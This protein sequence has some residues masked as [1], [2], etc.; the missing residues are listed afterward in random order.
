VSGAATPA[1]ASFGDFGTFLRF[2]R[3]RAR[4]TQRELGLR[5]GYSEGHICRLEQNRRLPELSVVAALFVPAL[6]L[7]RDPTAAGRLMELARRVRA[8][9]AAPAAPRPDAAESG[10]VPAAPPYAVERPEALA[11][12]NALLATEPVVVIRGLAG[13]GK[14][15]LA[16]MLARQQTERVVWWMTVTAGVNSSVD[17][18]VTR[19]ERL[20]GLDAHPPAQPGEG[21]PAQPLSRRVD[22][23]AAAL[24][25]R[26]TLLCV[27][28]AEALGDPPL[29]MLVHLSATAPL[30]LLLTSR[31]TLAVPKAAI[32]R[33]GGLE[34]DQASTLIAR[35]DPRV[36]RPL[37][38]RLVE[39]TGGNPMLLRL[40]L[41]QTHEPG[42]DH[43]ALVE[44]LGTNPDIDGYL[45]QTTVDGLGPAANRL[46]SLLG[47]F[48]HP[49]DLLD[50]TLIDLTQAVDGPYDWSFAVAELVRRQLIDDPSSASLHPLVRDHTRARLVGELG[51]RRRLHGV[52]AAWSEQARDDVLEAAW[53]FRHAGR[54]TQAVEVLTGR[55]RTLIGRGQ[56]YPAADLARDLLRRVPRGRGGERA[57]RL[58]VLLGDLLVGTSRAEEA[59]SAYQA[60]LGASTQPSVRADVAARLA[61]CLL[62]R[63]RVPEA[64]ALCQEASAQLGVDD[65]LLRARL[66]ATEAR[67]RLQLSEHDEALRVGEHALALARSLGWVA[68]EVAED[69][70]ASAG[71]TVG[72]V[73]RLRGR[74]VEA[75]TRLREAAEHARRAGLH[76]LAGRCQ[77]NLGAMDMERGDLDGAYRLWSEL[78]T[79]MRSI[80]ASY[81]LARLLHGLALVHWYRGERTQALDRFDEA[82]ALK[83]EL[84]DVQGLAN[85]RHSRALVLR[86]LHRVDEALGEL[87]AILHGPAA[88]SE[89]WARVNYL[90]SYATTLMVA[91]RIED[92]LEPLREALDLARHTGGLYEGLT[93]MHLALAHLASG[94]P[95]PAAT[96]AAQPLPGR[97][98]LLE[99]QLDARLLRAALALARQDMAGVLGASR[100]LA[101][102]IGST[103][104][105][106][107]DAVPDRLISASH[108]PPP[109]ADLPRLIWLP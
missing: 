70:A 49:A 52:A 11:R 30:R 103:G 2:L 76:H 12:V 1:V 104:M 6:G 21:E 38:E 19:L 23:V 67:A 10:A 69:V 39:R 98:S 97:Q 83:E 102:W 64:L 17:A 92:A 80:R 91:G 84:G 15:T 55:I 14:T 13:T 108:R 96:L 37:A 107:W 57:R 4:I 58:R 53:H 74:H 109:P 25:G 100:E 60:A 88:Q 90:D 68:P 94:D 59:E 24:A 44:G 105:H 101:A 8:R 41:G 18:I 77:F 35:L 79:S 7:A 3:R 32:Y 20:A 46:L 106:L 31:T 22:M 71:L 61:E 27:D 26:P 73:L 36:P 62:Q 75:S 16:S 95:G 72:V 65:A 56:A 63:A 66:A 28:G 87:A 48:R 34:P 93:S 51:R 33:L 47:V 5:V 50:E 43:V 9:G 42:I 29:A 78:E 85:S 54:D 86:G 99:E 82:C 89:G 81:G 40:A 45:L